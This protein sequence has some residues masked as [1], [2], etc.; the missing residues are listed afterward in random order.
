MELA[1]THIN[2]LQVAT[3]SEQKILW[4]QVAEYHAMFVQMADG[5]HDTAAVETRMI[6]L[7]PL[8]PLKH[9]HCATTRDF[10]SPLHRVHV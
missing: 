3:P 4:L 10:F 2:Q 6:R 5:K 9:L 7:E 1:R 8:E